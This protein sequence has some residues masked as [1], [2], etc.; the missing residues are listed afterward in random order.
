MFKGALSVRYLLMMMGF[1]AVY[2]GLIYNDFLGIPLD[3][4][5][6]NWRKSDIRPDHYVQDSTY[7]FGIDPYWY[8]A[9]N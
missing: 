6:T 8:K 7:P 3:F 9:D 5:G 1:F 4:F 2:N